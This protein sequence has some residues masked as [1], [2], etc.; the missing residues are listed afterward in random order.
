MQNSDRED[1]SLDLIEQW[2]FRVMSGTT[3]KRLGGVL[4]W[5]TIHTPWSIVAAVSYYVMYDV[6]LRTFNQVVEH[7]QYD[8]FRSFLLFTRMNMC[9]TIRS[10]SG[11]NSSD[12]PL[13]LGLRL[14]SHLFIRS[15]MFLR[16]RQE[17]TVS[18]ISTEVI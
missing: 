11:T 15:K 4:L 8:R 9:Y 3:L 17:K 7:N 14:A 5:Y 10:T 6:G 16:C 12:W 2:S 18:T 13:G 1:C